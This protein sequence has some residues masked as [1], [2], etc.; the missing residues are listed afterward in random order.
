[1]EKE[2][3]QKKYRLK[4][5]PSLGTLEFGDHIKS[6][7]TYKNTGIKKTIECVFTP[8]IVEKLL[9]EGIIEAVEEEPG[10]E[11]Q[12]N[13]GE[14]ILYLL[15]ERTERMLVYLKDIDRRLAALEEDFYEEES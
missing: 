2:K 14:E 11:Y 1:M 5:S 7:N 13:D 15:L 10:T 4:G 3:K 8:D 9:D 6:A 12:F